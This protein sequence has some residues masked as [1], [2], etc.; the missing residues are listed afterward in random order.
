MI[1]EIIPTNSENKKEN[2]N[3]WILFMESFMSH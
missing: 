1:I 2:I 3:L